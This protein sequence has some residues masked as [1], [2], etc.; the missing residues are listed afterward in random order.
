MTYQVCLI[1]FLEQ[2][3]TLTFHKNE[4]RNFMEMIVDQLGEEIG[5]C[6]GRAWCGTC[7]IETIEGIIERTMEL[8][9]I[10]TLSRLQN[11]NKKSR[12]ACQLM[13]DE[14]LNGLTF[15]LLT[16]DLYGESN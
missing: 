13:A 11:R 4:Y 3:H 1:N 12:L 15:K 2:K 16:E 14:N 9:E 6:K 5:D 7:H 8:D 10:G